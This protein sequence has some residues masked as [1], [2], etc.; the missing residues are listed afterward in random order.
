MAFLSVKGNP[1]LD[2]R[3][4]YSNPQVF[5]F[6]Q[7]VAATDN[8]SSGNKLGEGGFGPVYKVMY[9]P[10]MSLSSKPLELSHQYHQLHIAIEE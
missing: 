9:D 3:D 10:V 7:I 1:A 2:R 8:F 4:E 5:S 6:A